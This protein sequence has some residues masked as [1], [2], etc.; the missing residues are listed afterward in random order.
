[1]SDQHQEVPADQVIISLQRQLAEQA[2]RIAVL[3]VQLGQA[4]ST[5]AANNGVPA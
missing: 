4:Q 5:I 1:M 3:E 2:L